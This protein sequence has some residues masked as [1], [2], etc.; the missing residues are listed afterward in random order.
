[1]NEAPTIKKAVKSGNSLVVFIA[2]EAKR[3]GIK[4]GDY[5]A[6]SVEEGSKRIIIKKARIS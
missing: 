5:L 4:E 2:R 3:L 6:V 1:M